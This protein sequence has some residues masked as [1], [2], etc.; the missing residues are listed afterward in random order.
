LQWS[1]LWISI[2]LRPLPR[3]EARFKAILSLKEIIA[4]VYNKPLNCDL[5][6]K[7]RGCGWTIEGTWEESESVGSSDGEDEYWW[8]D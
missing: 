1:P 7:I 8:D 3:V 4:N 2:V 5:R 6:E